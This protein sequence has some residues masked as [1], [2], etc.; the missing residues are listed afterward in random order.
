MSYNIRQLEEK[1]VATEI[2]L[3]RWCDRMDLLAL[4]NSKGEILL[5]RL[6]WQRVWCL[7]PYTQ[8]SLVVDMA[9]RPDGKIIAVAYNLGHVVL[10]EVENKNVLRVLH[11]EDIITCVSWQH[12]KTTLASTDNLDQKNVDWDTVFD[13]SK[14]LP[15]L[16][17]LTSE[18]PSA[19]KNP[20]ENLVDLNFV[21]NQD[22]LNI[23]VIGTKSGNLHISIFGLFTCAL[24]NVSTYLNKKCT[25]LNVYMSENLSAMYVTICDD[26]NN[27]RMI[28][29]DT[30]VLSLYS[31]ELFTMALKHGH[32]VSLLSY[33]DSTMSSIT[34]AW[35][36]ILLE[37]DSKLSKYA[38]NVPEFTVSADFLD[39]LMFGIMSD[40]MEEFL[41]QDLTDKGLKKLGHSIELSY[42]NIQKLVLKHLTKVG[43]NITYHLAELRGMARLTL[44]YKNLG[45]NENTIT[46]AIM[47]NGAFLVKGVEVQQVIN[48][49]MTNYKAFFRWLYV[50]I[51][52][53]M[54][55]QIPPEIPKM[56]QQDV[57]YI[58]EFLKNFDS[59]GNNAS[60]QT[61]R[62]NLERLGQYLLDA[63]LKI[64]SKSDTN[65]WYNFLEERDCIASHESIIKHY[66]AMS[67]V[68]QHKH[69]IRNIE[70]IFIEPNE[71]ISNSFKFKLTFGCINIP[72]TASLSMTQLNFMENI[73][74]VAFT[75][76]QSANMDGIYFLEM[77]NSDSINVKLVYLY[78]SHVPEFAND[79]SFS[80]SSN[81]SCRILDVKFYSQSHLSIL[82]QHSATNNSYLCQIP[83]AQ[84][85]PYLKDV[86]LQDDVLI[87]G[88]GDTDDIGKVDVCDITG[89]IV[90]LVEGM[91]GSTFAVSSS[92]HVCVVLSENQRKVQLFEMEAD[93]DEDDFEDTY[94]TANSTKDNGQM[95]SESVVT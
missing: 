71:I 90:R 45:L 11:I 70:D 77:H 23:L 65:I 28:V 5:H 54:D 44:R 47:A 1:V 76:K 13:S 37:M 92:R 22:D 55:E 48:H 80:N 19:T 8:D 24:I 2:I 20:V 95:L 79:H 91:S 17:S 16:P 83:I 4:A 69:L 15:D 86:V 50:V 81:S 38:S 51:L 14:Y 57:A 67:L 35:E 3:M 72:E 53:L 40:E 21:K 59:I 25:I 7:A 63:P 60:G 34:E 58:T 52:R 62:F 49:S 18:F 32:L 61:G 9:W 42:S 33:L 89:N 10:V 93:E 39:L 46:S 43:E 87:I 56:A 82:L 6:T 75:D 12:D 74:C 27:L 66:E 73:T 26:L 78:A 36:S 85:K 68:Q 88:S 31:K 29:M 94:M 64:L 41:M 30:S 84:L